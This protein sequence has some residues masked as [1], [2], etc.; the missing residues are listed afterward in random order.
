MKILK[1]VLCF[2]VACMFLAAGTSIAQQQL[3]AGRDYTL[4]NPAQPTD[5][6]KQKIE[7]LE[8]FWYGCIHCYHLEPSMHAWLN[9][10]PA[11]V[12]FKYQPTIFD[13]TS[14]SPLAR[15]FYAMD[16]MG[17]AGK[18]HDDMFNAIHREGKNQLVTNPRAMADWLAAK[19]VDRQKFLDTYNSF[20][21]NTRTQRAIEMTRAY[22]VQGTPSVVIDGRYMTSPSMALNADQSINY[23]RFFAV[24]DQIIAQAR[25]EHGLKPPAAENK[26]TPA[27]K[28]A[29]KKG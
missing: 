21:V 16:A 7:V 5:S 20:A 6:G 28:P 2:A 13:V 15:F 17:L 11:D 1:S 3:V 8:F 25:K 4:I 18:Y 14:W 29:D 19:G 27:K 12:D 26:A 24:V 9:R 10:K 23:D 22:D